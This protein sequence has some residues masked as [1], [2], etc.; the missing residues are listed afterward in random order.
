M[1]SKVEWK[2]KLPCSYQLRLRQ[3]R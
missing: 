2:N 1:P 3:W